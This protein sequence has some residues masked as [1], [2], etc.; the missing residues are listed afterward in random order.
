MQSLFSV[1]DHLLYATP[2]LEAAVQDVENRFGVRAAIGGRHKA[3]GTWNALISL[4]PRMYLE[5]FGPDPE[6]G[7]PA[8]PRPFELDTLRQARLATWVARSDDLRAV[9][10]A[11]K[12]E[13]LDLGDVQERSRERPDGSLLKWTMTDPKKS[14][15]DGILPYFIHWGDSPHPAASSPGGCTLL[16]LKARHPDAPRIRRLL[17]ALELD[18]AVETGPKPGLVATN[19]TRRGDLDLG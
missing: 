1:L 8:G 5:L 4:G 10:E 16:A 12:R 7:S 18:L 14:R 19:R 6:Q 11:A 2:D 15:E 13:G 9:L 17:R 3:W